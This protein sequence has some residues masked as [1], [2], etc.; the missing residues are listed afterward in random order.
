MCR[1]H[2]SC[3]WVVL[4]SRHEGKLYPGISRRGSPARGEFP[5]AEKRR[6][7]DFRRCFLGQN[8]PPWVSDSVWGVQAQ[9]VGR[10][11]DRSEISNLKMLL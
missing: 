11:K 9:G 4:A 8:P 3:L 10:V 2:A 7:G 6:A 5:A 1:A